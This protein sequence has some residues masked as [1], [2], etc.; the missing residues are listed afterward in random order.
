MPNKGAMRLGW[1]GAVAIS[2][3]FCLRWRTASVTLALA[4]ELR[5][6]RKNWPHRRPRSN[7][8]AWLVAGGRRHFQATA[9]G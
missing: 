8:S 3:G 2:S 9:Q 1:M 6:K 4:C 7:G 5:A